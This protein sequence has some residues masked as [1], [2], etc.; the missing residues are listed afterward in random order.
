[1][2]EVIVIMHKSVGNDS[3]GSMWH[4]VVRLRNDTTL[5][6]V[7]DHFG[8]QKEDIIIPVQDDSND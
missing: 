7:I 6:D 8:G 2:K 3:V 1:M 5:K 4:E